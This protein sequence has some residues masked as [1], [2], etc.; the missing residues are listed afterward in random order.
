MALREH[1]RVRNNINPHNRVGKIYELKQKLNDRQL[2]YLVDIVLWDHDLSFHSLKDIWIRSCK[3]I[4][5]INKMWTTVV[6]Q[7]MHLMKICYK[8]LEKSITCIWSKYACRCCSTYFQAPISAKFNCYYWK[9]RKSSTF[10]SAQE[11]SHTS[12]MVTIKIENHGCY[13]LQMG[14]TS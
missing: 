8:K 5:N 14:N 12:G 11:R 4:R 1:W 7:N 13:I 9:S 3:S 2:N 6:D 10:V